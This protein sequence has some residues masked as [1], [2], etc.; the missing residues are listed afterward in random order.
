[1]II[2]L[3]G[4]L[5]LKE[6]CIAFIIRKINPLSTKLSKSEEKRG[7]YVIVIYFGPKTQ[8]QGRNVPADNEESFPNKDSSCSKPYRA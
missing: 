6:I 2:S 5:V 7:D 3:W 1:M 4:F 8:A